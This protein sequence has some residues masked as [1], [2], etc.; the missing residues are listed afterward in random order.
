MRI[1]ILLILF[2]ILA[3]GQTEKT[4]VNDFLK[5]PRFYS[6][7]KCSLLLLDFEK[8]DGTFNRRYKTYEYKLFK[9]VE[10]IVEISYV[11]QKN[12]TFG[13]NLLHVENL[14]LIGNNC[15]KLK[16]GLKIGDN[17][18]AFSSILGIENIIKTGNQVYEIVEDVYGVKKKMVIKCDN[19][20]KVVEITLFSI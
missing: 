4:L 11:N 5:D 3:F 16:H 13:T 2:P 8:S 1:I 19:T 9:T 14:F 12:W 15:I 18:S 20:E 10:A 6:D 17:L 7:E